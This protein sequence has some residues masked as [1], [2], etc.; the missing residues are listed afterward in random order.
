MATHDQNAGHYLNGHLLLAMPAIGDT[1]FNRA[2]IYVCAHDENGA[3]GIVI[4]NVLPN[5]ELG[6]LL[7]NLDIKSD[8]TLPDNLK[9]LP[10]LCGGP[11]E[12]ARGFL[13]HSN[14][15]TQADT[16]KVQ[17]DIHVTGTIDALVALGTN[18][19]PTQILF[20]LGYAGWGAGQ[21]EQE[22]REN[23]WLTVPAT[24]DLIFNNSVDTIWA[25]GLEKIGI[26]PDKLSSLTGSA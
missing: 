4:N 1:R 16:I 9:H 3:M 14:D 21:L 20:A 17:K 2:A 8:I 25:Q 22:V 11:V 13:L 24:P 15:F 23:A 18:K 19:L 10:V 12:S 26:T 7:E 5:L 6:K